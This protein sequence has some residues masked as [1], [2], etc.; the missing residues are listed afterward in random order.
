MKAIYEELKYEELRIKVRDFIRSITKNLGDYDKK[1]MK[2]KFDSDEELR[3]NELK[4]IDIKSHAGYCFDDIIKDVDINF[5]AILLGKK[6]YENISVYDISYK[7]STDPKPL[8]IDGFIRVYGSKTRHLVLFDYGLFDKNCDK[9]K[10]LISE[11]IGITDS[12]NHNF[13]KIRIVSY[14]PLP[15]EKRLTFHNVIILIRSVV[16]KNKNNY[17]YIFGERFV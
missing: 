14:K 16:Y 5:S 7:P 1:Y 12:I 11:K 4:E 13:G 3:V 17:Y 2:I 8:K 9:I 10:C 6:L 15:I